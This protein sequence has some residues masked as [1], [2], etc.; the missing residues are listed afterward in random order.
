MKIYL[1]NF[2][3]DSV[4]NVLNNIVQR[5]EVSNSTGGEV[6]QTGINGLTALTLTRLITDLNKEKADWD[7]AKK[8]LFDKHVK[9]GSEKPQIEAGRVIFKSDEDEEAYVEVANAY[10]PVTVRT[11]LSD[12][13]LGELR[14]VSNEYF[15]LSLVTK[16]D[17]RF[18][19][20]KDEKT[21]TSTANGKAD[22]KAEKATKQVAE[23][24]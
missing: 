22:E 10:T 5:S 9:G 15:F 3:L 14:V 16:E 13:D 19:E 23:K 12:K 24:E 4:P 2:E 1:K 21:T 20:P 7:E 18:K 8:K 17:A 11:L 6:R